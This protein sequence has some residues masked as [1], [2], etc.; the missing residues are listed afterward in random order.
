MKTRLSALIVVVGMAVRLGAAD[1]M[2]LTGYIT[3]GRTAS[4][5]PGAHQPVPTEERRRVDA[6]E[7][8]QTKGRE[9]DLV[10][11]GRHEEDDKW[12]MKWKKV[13]RGSGSAAAAAEEEA[14]AVAL[15][16]KRK[17]SS[18]IGIHVINISHLHLHSTPP[19]SSVCDVLQPWVRQ[20]V[21]IL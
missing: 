8:Q 21:T 3:V 14:G 4:E 19:M 12:W 17:R 20:K 18:S 15:Q 11:R 5:H 9:Q 1:A 16:E 13:R 7:I 10:L 2:T 6:E